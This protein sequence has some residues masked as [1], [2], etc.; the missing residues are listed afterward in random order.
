MGFEGES[1]G[2]PSEKPETRPVGTDGEGA[3]EKNEKN[4]KNDEK[5]QETEEQSLLLHPQKPNL[6]RARRGSGI[7]RKRNI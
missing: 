5:D 3:N 1:Y 7:L 2:P 4:E 6:R